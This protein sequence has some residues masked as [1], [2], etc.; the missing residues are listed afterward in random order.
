MISYRA[1]GE[2][3]MFMY[4]HSECLTCVDYFEYQ[5]LLCQCIDEVWNLS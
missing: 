5:P 3:S 1:V 4:I 2:Q